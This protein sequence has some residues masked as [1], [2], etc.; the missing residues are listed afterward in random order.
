MTGVA[1][2]TLI[3]K[4]SDLTIGEDVSFKNNTADL[5]G[6]ISLRLGSSLVATQGATLF[7]YNNAMTHGGA[8]HLNQAGSVTLDNCIIRGNEA[9]HSGAAIYA[10]KGEYL[11]EIYITSTTFER[12]FAGEQA[13]FLIE[14]VARMELQNCIFLSNKA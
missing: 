11:T 10:T 6:A 1:S 3:A 9:S 5:G 14:A 12:N 13:L 4:A 8:L 7:E 2:S